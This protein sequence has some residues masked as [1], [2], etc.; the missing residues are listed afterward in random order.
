MLGL[1]LLVRIWVACITDHAHHP[2]EIFQSFEQAHRVVFGYGIIPWE[3]RFGTRSWLTPGL[4]AGVFQVCR[5]F[6]LTDPGS[7]ILAV[8]LFLCCLSASLILSTY[9]IGR[10]LGSE[11]AGLLAA[12]FAAFWYELIYFAPRP[13]TTPL[14]T[15][16]FVGSL[17][18]ALRP[19]DQAAP[20]AVGV[21]AALAAAVRIQMLPAIAVVGAFAL[22]RW[23]RRTCLRAAAGA[24]AVAIAVAALD[25]VTWG[26]PFRS[27]VNNYVFNI[28]H[29]IS[30]AFGTQPAYW[31]LEV[32]AIT[33]GGL[34]VVTL[35][36]ALLRPR[37]VA[38]PLLCLVALLLAHSLIGHKEYRF[39][40]AAVPLS[41]VILA[42]L[43]DG[44]I[45]TRVPP[46]RQLFAGC[47]VAAVLAGLSLA[48]L[49][50]ALPGQDRVFVYRPLRRD[51]ALAM[52]RSLA[53]N[54]EVGA[55]LDLRNGWGTSGGYTNFHRD[56]PLYFGCDVWSGALPESEWHRYATHVIAR[57][58]RKLPPEFE[59]E[60]TYRDLEIWKNRDRK[61]SL[62]VLPGY[63]RHRL[64]EGIDDVFAPQVA[65]GRGDAPP[66]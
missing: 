28:V 32:L 31:F 26:A 13:L 65:P 27:Y 66:K 30:A 17:A 36:W 48:G 57:H 8:K 41:G 42:V 51:P 63:S 35:A 2:D 15:Y 20:W 44:A 24:G 19:P 47:A 25:Q 60:S 12:F 43:A 59:L 49:L 23:D 38:L 33:S 52:Y 16:A 61:G 10:R 37:A 11:R 62:P 5:I 14:A 9:A 54:P 4:V 6:G 58:G 29:G 7:Y 50:F 22:W 53:R 39:V 3:Y 64:H 21:L 40:F 46:A 1:G 18:L 45:A 56:V 34:F 55:L